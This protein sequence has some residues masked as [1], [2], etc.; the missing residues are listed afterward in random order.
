MFGC[1]S[2]R[3]PELDYLY[4]QARR[5]LPLDAVDD[6]VQETALAAWQMAGT[7]ERA[8][9]RT[10]VCGVLRHKVA[11]FYRRDPGWLWEMLNED[12]P[13][14][15]MDGEDAH[16][17]RMVLWRIPRDYS[18]VLWLR[19][20]AGLTLAEVGTA[21]GISAEAARGRYKRAMTALR[22]EWLA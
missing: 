14:Q 3:S 11:D 13:H 21:L 16:L 9:A 17:L 4:R 12:A 6:V 15:A 2:T 5:R 1:S 18:H 22:Q 8:G 19:F 20:Y 7:R 10:W